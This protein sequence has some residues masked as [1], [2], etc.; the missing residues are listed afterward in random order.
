M[1]KYFSTL[2]AYKDFTRISRRNTTMKKYL[3]L[4]F[5]SVPLTF[6]SCEGG[7]N[8]T[9]Y[10]DPGTVWNTT[11]PDQIGGISLAGFIENID[12]SDFTKYSGYSGKLEI[13]SPSAAHI[14]VDGYVRVTGTN[15]YYDPLYICIADG[16]SLKELFPVPIGT[17]DEYIYFRRAETN[18]LVFCYKIGENSYSFIASITVTNTNSSIKYLVPSTRI[19]AFNPEIRVMAKTI[20]DSLESPTDAS[21]ALAFH[22]YIVK[23][24]Y[25]DFDSL[26]D[27]KA[28]DALAVLHNEMAVCEGYATLYAALLRASGIQAQVYTGSNHA[29]NMIYW[30]GEWHD[31][32]TTWDDPVWNDGGTC[33]VTT[34]EFCTSDFPDG[35]NLRYTYYDTDFTGDENHDGLVEDFYKK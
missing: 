3:L 17:F 19:Q 23:L 29:W 20:I 32:D 7:E 18:N 6:A 31:V 34:G 27:R 21:I 33:N 11:L 30:T 15:S 4:L 13:T 28:Q 10:T 14:S 9:V 8:K 25:Y 22:D 2:N 1:P 12:S 26:T 35:E 24:L 16:T 5:I